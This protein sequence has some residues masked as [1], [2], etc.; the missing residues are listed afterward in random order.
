MH[1]YQTVAHT[2]SVIEHPVAVTYNLVIL[3]QSQTDMRTAAGLLLLLAT[4]CVQGCVVFGYF[5]G[6]GPMIANL[7]DPKTGEK[8][9]C[10]SGW[11]KGSDWMNGERKRRDKCIATLEAKG[12]VLDCARPPAADPAINPRDSCE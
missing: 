5:A 7:H 1:D 12:F 11:V 3:N 8:A 2:R 10:G 6:E 4:L 9:V